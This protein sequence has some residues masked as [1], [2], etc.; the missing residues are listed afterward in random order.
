MPYK[1]TAKSQG[2]H[3]Y[4]RALHYFATAQAEAARRG[5]PFCWQLHT[6]EGIGHDCEA[7]SAVCAHLW[8]HQRMPSA[9]QLA[10]L[11]GRRTA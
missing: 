6:V 9:A 1:T 11:A 8:F 10:A 2:N 4:A 3:R 5:L 7:M